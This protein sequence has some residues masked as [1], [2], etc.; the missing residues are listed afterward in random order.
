MSLRVIIIRPLVRVYSANVLS[1]LYLAK[2]G[3]LTQLLARTRGSR[4]SVI[5][6]GFVSVASFAKKIEILQLTSLART[7]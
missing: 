4:C 1:Q 6:I 7:F 2:A 3:I 5:S